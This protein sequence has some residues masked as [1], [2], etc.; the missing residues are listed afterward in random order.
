MQD[1]SQY[2][3]Q[4]S[5]L[6]I[7]RDSGS[8]NLSNVFLLEDGGF[9]QE[10]LPPKGF[11]EFVPDFLLDFYRCPGVS[12]E[13]C[14]DFRVSRWIILYKVLSSIP[15]S[16]FS[17]W[18][19]IISF[20]F[21]FSRVSPLF[22]KISIKFFQVFFLPEVFPRFL[23]I[24]FRSFQFSSWNFSNISLWN[25]SQIFIPKKLQF[26]S[27]FFPEFHIEISS[28]VSRSF[29]QDLTGI[30]SLISPG[31]SYKGFRRLSLDIL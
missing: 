28:K 16:G 10:F 5:S 20:A 11:T 31:I 7:Y 15:L 9:I 1:F 24:T 27:R 18:L 12:T 22:C 19:F 26:F 14:Y 21:K 23:G 25:H 30:S 4:D 13:G 3:F 29:P 17:G 8:L 6:N 2:S